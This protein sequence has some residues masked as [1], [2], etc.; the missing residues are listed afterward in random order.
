MAILHKNEKRSILSVLDKLVSFWYVD[1]YEVIANILYG[2]T[3][4]QLI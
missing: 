3:G 4:K 2:K 1:C